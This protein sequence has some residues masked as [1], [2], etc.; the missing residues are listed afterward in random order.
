[1]TTKAMSA[2]RRNALTADN[3][4]EEAARLVDNMAAV[5]EHA[6]AILFAAPEGGRFTTRELKILAMAGF[7]SQYQIEG[8]LGRI[9][10]VKQLLAEAGSPADFT[11]AGAQYEEAKRIEHEQ[12]PVLEAQINDLQRQVD[13][14]VSKRAA[15][16]NR[17][18]AMIM[19]RE[20]LQSQQLLPAWVWAEAERACSVE[21]S[22]I[23]HRIGVIET[24]ISVI[25][26]VQGFAA[27]SVEAM[28][29]CEGYREDLIDVSVSPGQYRNRRTGETY[30]VSREP[31]NE[32][33][34]GVERSQVNSERWSDYQEERLA[35]LPKLNHELSELQRQ[36][37]AAE[38]H[39]VEQY[40]YHYIS[41][42]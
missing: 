39:V 24:E 30:T 29:H 15:A 21:V 38:M 2:K 26:A 18:I 31:E 9:G 17:R 11:A 36:L 20:K 34:R 3:S 27:T 12:V 5:D 7:E 4:A 23:R 6:E 22:P 19:A 1:M 25:D 28:L 42:L 33:S 10:R 13:E 14:L 37:V 40:R 16:E 8:Q 35:Q 41:R 32:D